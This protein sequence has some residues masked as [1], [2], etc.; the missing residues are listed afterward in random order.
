[1]LVQ[2]LAMPEYGA[3][4]AAHEKHRPPVQLQLTKAQQLAMAHCHEQS[5]PP[6]NHSIACLGRPPCGGVGKALPPQ[7][8]AFVLSQCGLSAPPYTATFNALS[9]TS[10]Q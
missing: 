2:Q 10:A 3:R 8:M 6:E 4:T 1:M 9:V 5:P 7:L